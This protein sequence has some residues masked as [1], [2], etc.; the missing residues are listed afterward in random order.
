MC[1][2]VPRALLG[3]EPGSGNLLSLCPHVFSV[4]FPGG[5]LQQP[6]AWSPGSPLA[7]PAGRCCRM[8]WPRVS[9]RPN[10]GDLGGR[11]LTPT[12]GSAQAAS[13]CYSP[14][15]GTPETCLLGP[16]EPDR[17]VQEP[18]ARLLMAGDGGCMSYAGCPHPC[19]HHCSHP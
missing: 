14:A 16:S 1:L 6:L 10:R 19:P 4:V 7:R 11:E 8:C 2:R 5:C 18:W 12:S 3:M 17:A 15:A 9:K 13:A